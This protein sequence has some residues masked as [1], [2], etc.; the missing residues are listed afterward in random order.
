VYAIGQLVSVSNGPVGWLMNLT[1]HQ[2]R[3]AVVNAVSACLCLL[4]YLVL[5]PPF[6]LMGAAAAN[7]GAVAV[8]N[9][10]SNRVVRQRLGFRISVV[11]ALA[12]AQGRPR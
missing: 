2:S 3:S 10:W 1:G 9:L 12:S 4:G 11:R 8:K 7:A 6:G 5:I